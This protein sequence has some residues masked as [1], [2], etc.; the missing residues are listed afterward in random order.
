MSIFQQIDI[1]S[2]SLKKSFPFY[3]FKPRTRGIHNFIKIELLHPHVKIHCKIISKI[4]IWQ[5]KQ[6]FLEFHGN[7]NIAR[8]CN[9]IG[10]PLTNVF[11][12]LACN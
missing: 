4:I 6:V 11:I 10:Q 1:T 5:V 12:P 9:K 3:N 8:V 7:R 2:V